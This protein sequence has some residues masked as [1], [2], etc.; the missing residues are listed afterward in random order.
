MPSLAETLRMASE[1]FQ[2]QIGSVTLPYPEIVLD[3][4]EPED[5]AAA[6]QFLLHGPTPFPAASTSPGE[7]APAH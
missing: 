6:E 3:I 7:P 5:Y 1:H 4:D 2:V